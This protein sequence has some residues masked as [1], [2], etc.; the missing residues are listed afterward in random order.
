MKMVMTYTTLYIGVMTL[1]PALVEHKWEKGGTYYIEAK[2]I[3]EYGIESDW[4]LLK[5]SMPKTKDYIN[6]FLRFLENHPN[7]FPLLRQILGI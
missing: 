6:P 3:D 2:A 1:T 7:L 5:I 4:S